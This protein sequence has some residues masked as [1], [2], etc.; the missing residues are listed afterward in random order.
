MC[1]RRW[2]EKSL[3]QALGQVLPYAIKRLRPLHIPDVPPIKFHLRIPRGVG[4]VKLPAPI[5]HGREQYPRWLA[6]R[7]GQVCYCGVHRD[8]EVELPDDGCRCGDVV[9]LALE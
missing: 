5:G 3:G 9:E 6:K 2:T 7:T 1:R 4:S 8:D